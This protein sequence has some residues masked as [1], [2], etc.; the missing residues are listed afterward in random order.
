MPRKKQIINTTAPGDLPGAGDGRTGGIARGAA[1]FPIVGIGASAG[2][3]EAFEAFFGKVPA[4]CGMAFVLVPHLDPDHASILADILQRAA[5]IPVAEAEDEVI[6][7]PGHVYIIPPNRDMS[8][9]RGALKLCEPERPRGQR[10]PIDAFFRSLAEDCGER[11]VAIILSGTGTDGTQGL[12]AIVG[13][14][15]IGLVQDPATAKYDGMPMSAI[16][17]GFATHLMAVE[18]MPQALLGGAAAVAWPGQAAELKIAERALTGPQLDTILMLLRGATGHDFSLYKKSTVARRIARRMSQHGIDDEDD[19]AGYLKAH[20]EELRTLFRELLINVTSFF[21]DPA[22]F[23]ALKDEILPPMLADKP[24]DY[25]FRVWV[26]GCAS[27]EE[28]YTIAIVLRELVDE[29]QLRLKVQIYSTDLDSE[30]IA[31]ARAGFYPPNIAADLTPERLQRYFIEENGGYRVKKALREMVIFAI[32]SV[33]K[34]P[35]FTRLDLLSCRNLMIYLEPALQDRLVLAFHYALKPGGVLLLSPSESIGEH[36]ELFAPI[37]RKWRLYRSLEAAGSSRGLLGSG[38]PWVEPAGPHPRGAAAR[39]AREVN[40]AELTRTALLHSYA[41]ASVTTDIHGAIVYVHGDT[42]NYLRPA[43]GQASLDVASMARPGLQLDLLAAIH[44]AREGTAVVDCEA[45]VIDNG[46]RRPVCSSVRPLSDPESGQRFLVISFRE[47]AEPSADA[48]AAR[49]KRSPDDAERRRIETLERDLTYT[50]A[51]LQATIEDQQA[52]NEELKAT[53]EEMQSTN[54]ELQSTNEELETSKEELQSVNEELLTVNAELQAK[55]EQLAL[56]QNDMKNLLDNVG[57]GVVF[58]DPSLRIRRYTRDAVHI[59]RLME[60][61][62]GRP[63]ADIRADLVDDALLATAKAVLDSAEPREC[64]VQTL[65]GAPYLA[66]I[67]PYRTVDDRV[68][69]V[70]LAFTP[71]GRRIKAELAAE[72]LRSLAE[73]VVDTVREPLIVLDDRLCVVTSSRSFYRTFKVTPAETIAR[74]I[75][76]LGNGQ[77]DIPALRQLLEEILPHDSSFEDYIVEHD[78]PEIGHARMSLSGRR[79]VG[80]RSGTRLILLAIDPQLSASSIG[81]DPSAP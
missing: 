74:P 8:I 14:G 16:N 6:V 41:P 66:R 53:N 10:M 4:D 68:N 76:E 78:F 17:A 24:E 31:T 57:T 42:G 44:S 38:L 54:E 72:E 56:I 37:S 70:V 51:R 18:A 77:W 67:Q 7:R 46:N 12:R 52:G 62:V 5:A 11:A 81:A 15:G 47:G 28:A 61:D 23:A 3:L 40:L 79:V 34:D 73:A 32:Q 35:P 39:A 2:G 36:H 58:L 71:I 30:A 69:G 59:Y 27:G 26:A 49:P 43:P 65:A 80:T 45:N 63:L 50:R 64:E 75:Y 13:A 25:V 9:A 20:P 29:R 55:I 21:R 19:Y 48:A 33:V 22:A 60:S 1:H